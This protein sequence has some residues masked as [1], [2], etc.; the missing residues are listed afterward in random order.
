MSES[1][2][3]ALI[4]EGCG[5]GSTRPK[6]SIPE[7]EI[8]P[9]KK[10]KSSYPTV[11]IV[12]LDNVG[13]SMVIVDL[14]DGVASEEFVKR[15]PIRLTGFGFPSIFVGGSTI[16]FF[17]S[18]ATLSRCP[19]PHY[20]NS[21]YSYLLSKNDVETGAFTL[22]RS[23]MKEAPSLE[24]YKLQPAAI[25]Y[26]TGILVFSTLIKYFEL[27]DPHQID[28]EFY[29]PDDKS[30]SRKLPALSVRFRNR[31]RKRFR[32]NA[33]DCDIESRLPYELYDVKTGSWLPFTG[34]FLSDWRTNL[35]F[36]VE[37]FSLMDTHTF[38]LQSEFGQV[39]KLNLESPDDQGWQLYDD[40]WI[41]SH[42]CPF[43]VM[44]NQYVIDGYGAYDMKI[45]DPDTK[46]N[47]WARNVACIEE[48]P[49]TDPTTDPDPDDFHPD[50]IRRMF[51]SKA[52][53]VDQPVLFQ[54]LLKI[55]NEVNR[56]VHLPLS[57]S[58]FGAQSINC[59]LVD[60]RCACV[61][62]MGIDYDTYYPH[63]VID[64][65][66]LD[67]SNFPRLDFNMPLKEQQEHDD[68]ANSIKSFKFFMERKPFM[69]REFTVFHLLSVFPV[70]F[71]QNKV[72][73]QEKEQIHRNKE[74]S[75]ETKDGPGIDK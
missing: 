22:D 27:R 29:N 20:H 33:I 28:F 25:R 19:H 56:R 66:R 67:F 49:T 55:V 35:A 34:N 24:C 13:L 72:G 64:I 60:D 62:Q 40:V 75:Q 32:R 8:P 71:H 74:S 68:W 12:C 63:F 31:Y 4:L 1:A 48:H 57:W 6:D 44:E 2:A 14:N 46:F 54:H 53:D 23:M 59:T 61:V 45:G 5:D 58:E 69:E 26:G 17:D 41:M 7:D 38:V 47:V 37:G 50:E 15:N 36:H 11:C 21:V 70:E 10:S 18:K 65:M 52:K 9:P 30:K 42:R 39:F 16:Y 43:F 51:N 3:T 73:C